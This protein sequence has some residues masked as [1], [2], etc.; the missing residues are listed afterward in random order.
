M[1]ASATPVPDPNAVQPPSSFPRRGVLRGGALLAGA[2]A[3][4]AAVALSPEAAHAADGDSVQLG[5]DNAAGSTTTLTIGGSQGTA[6]PTLALQNVAGP[7][8]RLQSLP[9]TFTGELGVGEIAGTAL[10]P[11]IGVETPSGPA[12]SYLVTGQDLAAVPALFPVQPF[13]ALDLRTA[14]GRE[15]IIRGSV[16]QPLT[17]EGRLRAG[18]WI[19]IAL[20]PDDAGFVLQAFF[21]NLTAAGARANGFAA[22]YPPGNRPPVSTLSYTPDRTISN[23][24]FVGTGSVSGA[25]AV[26]LYASAESYFVLDVTGT[27]T[28]DATAAPAVAAARVDG[29]RTRLLDRVRAA[30]TRASR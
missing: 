15:S 28:S 22:L 24:A 30:V 25:Y 14:A 2:A 11:I 17:A 21:G 18:Q 16:A 10:G 6:A 4:A 3:G 12:T 13:R 20:L 1:P 8:L 19:D 5:E 7:S 26:R 27:L 9:D 29:K 23:A